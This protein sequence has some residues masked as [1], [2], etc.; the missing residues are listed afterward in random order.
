MLISLIPYVT[1]VLKI[2]NAV[3]RNQLLQDEAT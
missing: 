3:L 1:D 2:K